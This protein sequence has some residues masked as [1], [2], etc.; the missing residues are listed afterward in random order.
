MSCEEVVREIPLYG[1]G[2][3]SP[4]TEERVESHLAECAACRREMERQR[5]FLELLDTRDDAAAVDAALLTRCRAGL[6][7]ALEEEARRAAA[8]PAWR[9]WWDDVVSSFRVP[10]MVRVPVGAVA[11]FAMGFFAARYTQQPVATGDAGATQASLVQPMFSTVRSVEPASADGEIAIA[12]DDVARHVVRGRVD[13]PRIQQ[14]L[15]GAVREETNPGIRA[16]SI[17][18]L[19][20]R[21][22]SQE[23]RE[24]LIEAASHDPSAA[25]RLRALEGLRQQ[26]ANAAVRQM[27]AN[28]LLMDDDAGVRSGAIDVLSGQHDASMVG[29]L[30]EVVQQEDDNYVRARVQQ[31]LEAM[32]ASVGTY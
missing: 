32:R 21:A 7:G 9:R 6:R 11:L 1:Y 2:E 24:A 8:Q 22:A 3:V 26:A 16:Q 15:L 19:Q 5:A 4:E 31:L 28:V 10:V 29:M 27:L 18:V 14:L 25:I 30:Q 17:T 20:G 23:V 12:V 13:D